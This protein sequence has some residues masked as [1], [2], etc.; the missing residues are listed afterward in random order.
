M[1]QHYALSSHALTCA[2][3]TLAACRSV[4][5]LTPIF[6]AKLTVDH[7]IKIFLQLIRPGRRPIR[8]SANGGLQTGG[9][10]RVTNVPPFDDPIGVRNMLKAQ[11]ISMNLYTILPPGLYTRVGYPMTDGA[12][13][14]RGGPL[15]AFGVGRGCVSTTPS[16]VWNP[17]PPYTTLLKY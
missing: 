7:L 14:T 12:S 5:G 3:L 6:G 13:G 15:H 10:H 8:R 11:Q 2:L 4:L 1:F 17:G 16:A 9:V